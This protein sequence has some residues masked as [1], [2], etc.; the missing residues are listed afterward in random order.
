MKDDEI[1]MLISIENL[2][3]W[4]FYQYYH[5]QNFGEFKNDKMNIYLY[6]H[7]HKMKITDKYI[8]IPLVF[9]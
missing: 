7:L 5:Y 1:N 3:H 4:N 9:K 2:P 6:N 8:S